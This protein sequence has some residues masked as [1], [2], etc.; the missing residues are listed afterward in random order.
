MHAEVDQQ[1]ED[2]DRDIDLAWGDSSDEE[3]KDAPKNKDKLRNGK[4]RAN[5]NVS[6]DEDSDAS[7]SS[8]DDSDDETAEL[9]RELE[10][11]R[12]EREEE[13]QI[14]L[15]KQQ[16]LEEKERSEAI[17]QGNPLVGGVAQGY[18]LKRRWDDDVVF[19]N[20]ANTEPETK[21][22]FINDTV[23]NDFHVKFLSRYVK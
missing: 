23:R 8:D 3:G 4:M 22:R 21:K 12:K 6:D 18:A 9:M 11:I 5:D 19:R 7:S 20:Q 15:K 16:M 2:V 1:W 10:R 17:T 13:K 14:E